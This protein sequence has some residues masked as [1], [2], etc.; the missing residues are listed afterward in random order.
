M[1]TFAKKSFD[2]DLYATARP[3]YPTALY[4]LVFK[5]HR[6][7]RLHFNSNNDLDHPTQDTSLT[8]PPEQRKLA[9]DLGCGPGMTI[10]PASLP[11]L[12]VQVSRTALSSFCRSS[13]HFSMPFLSNH[14]IGPKREHDCHS[15]Q[16]HRSLQ[17]AVP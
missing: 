10:S 7:G 8:L 15:S 5:Y 2:A 11:A 3:T 13:Y 17:G 12:G 4:D 14:W 1:T 16:E 9:V 6:D